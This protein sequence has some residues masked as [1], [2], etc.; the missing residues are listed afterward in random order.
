MFVN[1]CKKTGKYLRKHDGMRLLVDNPFDAD[2]Y[3]D[4]D[5]ARDAGEHWGKQPYTAVSRAVAIRN[6]NIQKESW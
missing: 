5:D 1:R 3:A 4:K 2:W 6:H